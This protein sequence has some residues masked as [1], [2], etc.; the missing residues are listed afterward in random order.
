[1]PAEALQQDEEYRLG[2]EVYF[3]SSYNEDKGEGCE[4]VVFRRMRTLTTEEKLDDQTA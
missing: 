1:M 4:D 3:L 2:D